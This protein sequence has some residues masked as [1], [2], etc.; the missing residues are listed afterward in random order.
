M[1]KYKAFGLEFITLMCHGMLAIDFFIVS[2][3]FGSLC[4]ILLIFSIRS[5]MLVIISFLVSCFTSS[6]M[7]LI[8]C[9]SVEL[10][11][12]SLKHQF[13]FCF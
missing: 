9:R 8:G 1:K 4:Q 2:V 3:N 10:L 11:I 12:Q 7:F 13:F 5:C 6:Q